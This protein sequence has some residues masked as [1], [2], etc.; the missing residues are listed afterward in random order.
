MTQIDLFP[1][2]KYKALY[3]KDSK[4]KVRVYF[5]CVDLEIL[6][7]PIKKSEKNVKSNYQVTRYHGIRGGKIQE[8][9]KVIKKGLQGR[10]AKDQAKLV[11]DSYYSKKKDEGYKSLAEWENIIYGNIN[12]K[13]SSNAYRGSYVDKVLEDIPKFTTD[14]KGQV[15][16]MLASSKF[17]K[18]LTKVY[19]QPKLNGVRCLIFLEGDKIKAISRKGKSYNIPA[20]FILEEIHQILLDFRSKEGVDLV[21]DGELY[22]HGTSLQEISRLVRTETP[23]VEQKNLKFHYYDVAIEGLSQE[24]RLTLLL[25]FYKDYA[26]NLENSYEVNTGVILAKEFITKDSINSLHN[27]YLEKGMEGSILRTFE[28]LYSFG[29]RS[30]SLIKVKDFIEEEFTIINKIEGE[31]GIEDMVFICNQEDGLSFR[32]KPVGDREHKE[33]LL[34]DDNIGKKLTVRYFERS[35]NNIPLHAVGIS[36][37]DY[38]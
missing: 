1:L 23:I 25:K 6:K 9:N 7:S 16:P 20:R 11:A 19:I 12:N 24:D 33:S 2:P 30:K 34:L 17:P 8:V 31:R 36:I 35:D 15:K 13:K 4:G 10:S 21:L 27:S 14:A 29:Q 3:K 18:N 26:R 22:I 32:V 5:I 37:R 28:G 38:E